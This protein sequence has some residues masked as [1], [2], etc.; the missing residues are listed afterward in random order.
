MVAPP[1]TSLGGELSVS[2]IIIYAILGFISLG[3]LLYTIKRDGRSKPRKLAFLMFSTVFCYC[4]EK[5]S[6]LNI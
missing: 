4:K 1:I 2:L 3:W 6:F 5:N